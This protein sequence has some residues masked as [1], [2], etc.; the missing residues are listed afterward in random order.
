MP[1]Y[2]PHL[3]TC[4]APCHLTC[5]A[6]LP[7]C[8][9]L[10]L[11]QS[12]LLFPALAQ[13]RFN[14]KTCADPRDLGGDGFTASDPRTERGKEV[15]HQWKAKGQC[16]RGDHCS[17]RHLGC[18]RAKPTPKAVFHPLSHQ[19]QGRSASRKRSHRGRSPSGKTDRQPCKNFLKSTC[20][21]LPCDYW[22]PPECQ[23]YKSE[24]L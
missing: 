18:E 1:E 12:H 4:C 2:F 20:T 7:C 14:L 5:T 3:V 11:P 10:Y 24:S 15:C 8:S 9:L 13:L 16:S 6:R 19:H 22:H 21:Q 17:F 23:F